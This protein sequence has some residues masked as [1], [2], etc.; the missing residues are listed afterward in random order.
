VTSISLAVN[1]FW[2]SFVFIDQNSISAVSSTGWN[3]ITILGLENTI[4]V[5]EKLWYHSCI[6]IEYRNDTKVFHG[7]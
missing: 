7:L 4:K 6:R 5:H 3:Q 2:F 1:L